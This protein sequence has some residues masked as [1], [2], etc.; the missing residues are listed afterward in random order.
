[1]LELHQKVYTLTITQKYYFQA[2]TNVDCQDEP[3]LTGQVVVQLVNNI[4]SRPTYDSCSEDFK[5]ELR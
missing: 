1:M 3:S 5:E 2:V 4:L